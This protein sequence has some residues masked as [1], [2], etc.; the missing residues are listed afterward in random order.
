MR[1]YIY[2]AARRLEYYSGEPI[3]DIKSIFSLHKINMP[4]TRCFEPFA[5]FFPCCF[6]SIVGSFN[7]ALNKTLEDVLT[8]SFSKAWMVADILFISCRAYTMAIL[9]L[10]YH[11]PQYD[12]TIFSELWQDE[13]LIERIQD[14]LPFK[15]SLTD[16]DKT[17]CE[18]IC[19]C[20]VYC[21][22]EYEN[23]PNTKRLLHQIRLRL[24]SSKSGINLETLERF[25]QAVAE[26]IEAETETPSEEQP[27]AEPP[28][29]KKE[30][31][32]APT[33]SDDEIKTAIHTL[34]KEGYLDTKVRYLG[35]HKVLVNRGVCDNN[36]SEFC[37]YMVILGFAKERTHGAATKRKTND[38]YEVVKK[39]P[40]SFRDQRLSE[41]LATREKQDAKLQKITDTARRLSQLIPSRKG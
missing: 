39:V 27:K 34:I 14:T 10:N 16:Y 22:L 5:E 35:I 31:E 19:A 2:G 41:C 26:S 38:I 30:E 37:R 4:R 32:A 17:Q 40:S 15:M 18:L 12:Y 23:E 13:K 8:K 7:Y 21:I 33:L 11:E 6:S 29:E 24:E 3:Y 20:M 1:D 25:R 36:L 9:S 28:L